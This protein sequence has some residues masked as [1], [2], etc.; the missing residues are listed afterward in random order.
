MVRLL[1]RLVPDA[2][3]GRPDTTAVRC[4]DQTLTYAELARR[5]NG[6]ARV[7]RATSCRRG[8]RVAVL[9]GKSA[10]V[11]VSFH[12]TLS[13]GATL[14]PVDP[15]SPPDQIRAILRATGATHLV[16]EPG[17]LDD[18]RRA[19]DGAPSLRHVIGIH[20]DDTISAHATPWTTVDDEA[21]DDPPAVTI[22]EV[23]PAYILHTSGS[24]GRPKLILHTHSSAMSFVEW[25]VEEYALT[26]DD[27]LSQHS[28]HHT[29]FATFDLYASARAGAATVILTPAVLMMPGSLSAL[30]ERERVTVW[31]SVPTALVQLS[32][33]GELESRDLRA[34]RWVLFAGETFPGGHLR[35]LREQ[36][37]HARFSHVYGSTELNVCTYY[38]LPAGDLPP[39][40][41]PIGRACSTSTTL[42]ADAALQPVADGEMGDLLVRG[43]TVMSGYLDDPARNDEVLVRRRG[44]NDVDEV[45]FRTGDRARV[46]PD[47]TLAF[48]GRADRQV[49]V[50][51]HRIE[52]D[53][54]ESALLSLPGIDEA[55]AF[56]MPDE[57]G[58]LALHAAIVAAD[59]GPPPG[60]R[61]LL[62]DLRKILPAHA[63]PS[64]IAVID[65]MP[66]TPTGK[67]D[68]RALAG[69]A[70][71]HVSHDGA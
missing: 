66:R 43:S 63:V 14:V 25:A 67:I 1:N 40:A 17:R 34:L 12:G 22:S 11:P 54:I 10:L 69:R 53:E 13:A 8:D 27:R 70:E 42:V 64:R 32:R 48:A 3:L 50:R 28:S 61:Q 21:A 33:R 36:L 4:D 35:R 30:L 45:Y 58:G 16:T 31:Y 51:G 39:G 71:A 60:E 15:K 26:P 19:L 62:A 18:V 29:C 24:T 7:L 52:L 55:A 6:L 20:P 59:G 57:E 68:I 56:T 37:P 41:L 49:K 44:P 65:A 47:G 2:A 38:H 46:L 5:C 9:L 23:D